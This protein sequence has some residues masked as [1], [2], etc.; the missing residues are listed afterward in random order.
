MAGYESV[1]IYVLDDT[2]LHSPVEG[3]LVRIFGEDNATFFTQDTTDADGHV[4]FTLWTQQ[5]NLRFYKQGAQVQ[6]P[7]LIDVI[8]GS[9]NSFNVYAT[10][11]VHPIAND[12]RLCRCSGFFRDITGAPHPWLDMHF[13]GQFSPILLE[14]AAVLSE[15]RSIR[16]DE[17]GYA[18]I[19]LIR[20][21][22]YQV[23]VEGM[24]DTLR[25]I[26]VP[27]APSANLPDLLFTVVEEITFDP[28]GPYNVTVGSTLELTPTVVGSNGVPLEG[29][30]NADVHWYS[31]DDSV[32]SVDVGVDKITL[33]GVAA[34]SADLMAERRDQSIIRIPSIGI[35]GVPQ[36]V[37]VA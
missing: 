19:D 35:V 12:P 17:E 27:D 4:G 18:C 1:D 26:S 2:P 21:A 6:Q 22:C 24:E 5:Y 25:Q 15:R 14:G 32:L 20:G 33:L 23:T 13:L 10:V 31:S 16:T 29:T 8:E 11:F 37:T 34:G 36:V 3:L 30:A 7:Q 9:T 28:E